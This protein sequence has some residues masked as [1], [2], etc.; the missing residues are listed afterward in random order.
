MTTAAPARPRGGRAEPVVNPYPLRYPE[1]SSP[2]VMGRRAWWLVVLNF[3]IP[4]SAQVLAGNRR[5]GRIGLGAT[6]FMWLVLVLV[7]L[8]AL[9]WRS[10]LVSVGTNW[11]ALLVAQILLYA[12]AALWVLLTIDTVRLARL[13]RVAPLARIG[14][15]LLAVVLAFFSGSSAVAAANIAGSTRSAITTIFGASAALVPPS[16][17]YYNILLLGAD[18]GDGRDSMRFDSIS[19]VSVNADSGAVTIFGLP[20]DMPHAPFPADSPMHERYPDGFEGHES[21]TCGWGSGLNQLTNAVEQCSDDKGVSL[22]P[23]AA[24]KGSRPSIEATKDAAEGILGISIPYYAFADMNGFAD[25]IDALGGI[26]INV[27]ERLPKGYGPLGDEPAEVWAK[28]WIEPGQQHM[29]GDTA[30][31]YARSRYTTSDWDRMQRQRQLQEAILAQFSPTNVLT[32]FQQV[33]AAS[34]DLVTTDIPQQL[35]PTLVDLAVKAK[36]QPVTTLDLTPANGVDD[37][38]PDFAEI[39]PMVQ[40]MLHPPSPSPAG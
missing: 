39:P 37:Q 38:N 25:L 4:G 32:H 8:S 16:D 10:A 24:A 28:G 31:W 34:S 15:L 36:G 35:L 19:V 9:L 5:L 26:D 3:L 22:Y 13:V 30:Q 33:A 40:Q 2:T 29:D 12:Y 14:V 20:R 1:A 18:S 21:D 17:G 11:F 7:V 23:D 6:L 27:T